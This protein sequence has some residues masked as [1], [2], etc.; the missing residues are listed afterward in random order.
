MFWFAVFWPHI[1]KLAASHVT[2]L[3]EMRTLQIMNQTKF[4]P[5]GLYNTNGKIESTI[6]HVLSA[7]LISA[8]STCQFLCYNTKA[9]HV[10][11]LAAACTHTKHQITTTKSISLTLNCTGRQAHLLKLA[12]FSPGL[13]SNT[14]QMDES[15]GAPN[16]K[17]KGE[18]KGVPRLSLY[19]H[20]LKSP[21][22]PSACPTLTSASVP[23]PLTPRNSCVLHSSS[24]APEKCQKLC[25]LCWFKEPWSWFSLRAI[26]KRTGME[27]T[28]SGRLSDFSFNW[29]SSQSHSI[30]LIIDTGPS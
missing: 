29:R 14:L 18:K 27:Q 5:W 10:G 1:C 12:N 3:L 7:T 24:R 15:A 4:D 16:S 11:M 2:E 26:K 6:Y 25:L 21:T 9:T 22:C 28:E 17:L 13:L 19:T 8:C 30:K 20:T 23:T